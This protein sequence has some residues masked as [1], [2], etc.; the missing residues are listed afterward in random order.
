MQVRIDAYRFFL[1]IT[2]VS[3]NPLLLNI[4]LLCCHEVSLMRTASAKMTSWCDVCTSS[5]LSPVTADT[6]EAAL[7]WGGDQELTISTNI[8]WPDKYSQT[9]TDTLTRMWNLLLGCFVNQ[10]WNF[11]ITCYCI[12]WGV[13]V[14][15]IPWLSVTLTSANT[16]SWVPHVPG[17]DVCRCKELW[18]W[19]LG[20]LMGSPDSTVWPVPCYD[21]CRCTEL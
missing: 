20:I 15:F 12:N 14:K 4:T 6:G 21:V 16:W 1:E 9:Q 7:C 17:Y 3:S 18:T 13:S 8:N 5:D 10:E 11:A 2:K 19:D